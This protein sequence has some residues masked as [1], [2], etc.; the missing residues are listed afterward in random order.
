MSEQRN[1]SILFFFSYFHPENNTFR[2]AKAQKC[3]IA[4]DFLRSNFTPEIFLIP[5]RCS[6][7]QTVSSRDPQAKCGSGTDV[8]TESL[9]ENVFIRGEGAAFGI[10]K[11]QQELQYHANTC[12]Y[13]NT[14]CVYEH[15]WV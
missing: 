15:G 1:H 9:K 10:Q 6:R 13:M 12:T 11:T 3:K 14:G 8:K 5:R 7:K 4:R 2:G